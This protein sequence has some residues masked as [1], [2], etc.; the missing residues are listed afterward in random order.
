[1]DVAHRKKGLLGFATYGVEFSSRYS[2]RNPFPHP[3]M[4]TVTF[5]YPSGNAVYDNM[6][7]RVPGRADVE[8][9]TENGTMSG[10]FEVAAYGEQRFDFDYRSRGMDRWNY[11]FGNS[12]KLVQNFKLRMMTNFDEID[13]PMGS[14]SPDDKE[15]REKR[16]GWS[17]TWEKESLVSG[18]EIGMLMPHKINPGPLAAS[19]SLHAP[20]S[21]FFFFFVLF[22]LQG[23]RN[24]KIHPMNYFFIAASFFAFKP[25]F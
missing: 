7:V 8:I 12:V 16:D 2:V 19:M 6:M 21:L 24:L 13:F 18:L 20:V 3:V 23:L 9:T 25:L 4:V 11:R 22:I 14:I 17:L 15:P 5:N 1:M 10:A